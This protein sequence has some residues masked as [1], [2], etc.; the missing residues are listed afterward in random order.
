MKLCSIDE[1]ELR[2]QLQT[3]K[4]GRNGPRLSNL[5]SGNLNHCIAPP[6]SRPL[7]GEIR[8]SFPSRQEVER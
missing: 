6:S 2:D 7:F 8:A 3:S 4:Q 5:I 1:T